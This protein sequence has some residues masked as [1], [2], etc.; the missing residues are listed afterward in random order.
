MLRRVQGCAERFAQYVMTLFC[1]RAQ[2]RAST[3][4]SRAQ[5]RAS[6]FCSRTPSRAS[7][8]C[9]RAQSRASTFCS[10]AQSRASTLAW[11]L[12]LVLLARA[13]V[14]FDPALAQAP[15]ISWR[16]PAACPTEASVIE[17]V[18]AMRDRSLWPPDLR[19]EAQVTRHAA[20]YVLRLAIENGG[21]RALREF[22]SIHCETL[23]VTAAWLIAVSLDSALSA[24]TPAGGQVETS[25]SAA[26]DKDAPAQ[27]NAGQAQGRSQSEQQSSSRAAE[28]GDPDNARERSATQFWGRAAA[29]TGV[30][31]AGLPGPQASL[32]V[33]GGLGLGLL[34]F[35]LR[36]AHV[37]SRAQKV[38]VGVVHEDSQE[39]GVAGCAQWG[40]RLR[41]GPCLTLS[42]LRT[43]AS[44]EGTSDPSDTAI[45]WGVAGIAGNVSWLVY[46]P[47][48][49]LAEVGLQLPISARPRFQV[50]GA[51]E[52]DSANFVA[53]YGQLSVGFRIE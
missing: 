24:T 44:I 22:S 8:F 14:R 38:P 3:F 34:Y 50:R 49:L 19:A 39:L 21:R 15:D 25:D 48:E 9:S 12:V 30:F 36:V 53:G 27:Q 1:S 11:V 13:T 17:R 18:D 28:N 41:G 4:C 32:G 52:V 23:A 40:E 20:R 10:R 45:F 33:R 46:A 37:F 51:A 29:F 7:T 47:L 35:E 6:T 16:A 31:G 43:H 5:S 2:S 42:G 26:P